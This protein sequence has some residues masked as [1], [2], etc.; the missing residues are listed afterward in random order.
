ML[1]K[2][3]GTKPGHVG[4]EAQLIQMMEVRGLQVQGPAGIP[5]KSK[6]NLCTSK[7]E[8]CWGCSSSVAQYF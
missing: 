6:A 3:R 8:R 1:L 5:R 4:L 7:Q 2:G